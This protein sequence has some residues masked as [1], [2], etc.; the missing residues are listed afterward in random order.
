ME[1]WAPLLFPP[2]PREEQGRN[3]LPKGLAGAKQ[4]ANLQARFFGDH[5][6]KNQRR[7]IDKVRV[8]T[9]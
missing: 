1:G 3:P 8:W 6:P 2:P 9:R 4:P 5:P 7:E